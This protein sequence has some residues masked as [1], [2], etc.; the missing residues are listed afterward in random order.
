VAAIGVGETIG[1]EQARRPALGYAMV[2]AAAT[3][4][5]LNGAVSK[6]VLTSS[7][8]SLRLTEVRCLGAFLGLTVVALLFDRHSF[9]LRTGEWRRLAVFGVVGVAGVQLFYFL[10]IDRLP[11][12]IALLIQYLGPLLVAIWVRTFGHE[13]IRRRVW[14][15]LVLALVGLVLMVQIWRGSSLDV[16]GVGFGLLAAA[17]YA[18][19]LL[20]AERRVAERDSISLLVWGFLFASVFWTIAQPWW[21]F[22]ASTVAKTVALEGALSSWHLPAWALLLWVIVLGTIAPFVLIVGALKHV[23]A[24]RAG[25][26][27]MLEPVIATVLGWVW[28]QQTLTPAQLVG[29][30]V[31]L[32]GIVLA[33]TAR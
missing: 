23:T 33:Q 28:L 14:A 22:P 21:S 18:S 25:I 29:A 1:E 20:L 32:S 2:L 19:Y 16:L 15:A 4:F 9:R 7:L 26:V 27:A 30:G 5:G 17:A 24:T 31:V 11:L 8:G 6:V 13:H 3:L 10:A 12:G